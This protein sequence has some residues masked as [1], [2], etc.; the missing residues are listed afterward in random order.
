MSDKMNKFKKNLTIIILL[1]FIGVVCSSSINANIN[2]A[3]I[4]SDSVDNISEICGLDDYNIYRNCF[5]K[6]GYVAHRN[7]N[8]SGF[9]IS[10]PTNFCIGNIKLDL[11]NFPGEPERVRLI[12]L[13]FSGIKIYKN[14]ISV[15][16][17]GFIGKVCPTGSIYAGCLTGFA[18]ITSITPLE[19]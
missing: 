18:M 4:D 11:K 17:K 13:S 7:V 10:T 12:I 1:L 9:Y 14:N 15:S 3:S 8:I 19:N 16:L 5:V 2:K 6:S